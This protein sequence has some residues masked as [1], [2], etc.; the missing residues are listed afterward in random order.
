MIL[1][2][3]NCTNLSFLQGDK[4]FKVKSEISLGENSLIGTGENDIH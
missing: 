2:L 1:T 3:T 4:K